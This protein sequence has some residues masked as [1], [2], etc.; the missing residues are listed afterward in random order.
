LGR[1]ISLE[2]RRHWQQTNLRAGAR[3]QSGVVDADD[4]VRVRCGYYK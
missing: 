1:V 2:D 3:G 4:Y